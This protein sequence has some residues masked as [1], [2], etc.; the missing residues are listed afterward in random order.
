MDIPKF[1]VG[2]GFH[3][4]EGDGRREFFD[5][6][7]A[8]IYKYTKP[9]E[10]FVLSDSGSALP[11]FSQAGPFQAVRCTGDLGHF[12]HLV[13]HQKPHAFNGW[14]GAIITLAMIAYCDEADFIFVEQDALAFGPWVEKLYDEIGTRGAL[15]GSSTLMACE[16][17][18]FILRHWAIPGFVQQYLNGPPQDTEPEL[19]EAKFARMERQFPHLYGRFSMGFGRNRPIDFDASV[20]YAQKYTPD[21]LAELKNRGLI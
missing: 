7:L 10:V 5:I 13:N 19:G 18:V 11:S 20:F 1:I 14:S 6:W 12:M 16:Q 15:W 3:A 9:A 8:N 2:G 21:E 17:S 4:V